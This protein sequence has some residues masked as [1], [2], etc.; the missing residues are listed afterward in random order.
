MDIQII[1]RI[2]MY[3]DD[4]LSFIR[5]LLRAQTICSASSISFFRPFY[6]VLYSLWKIFS[7][8]A[9]RLLTCLS[10]LE[11]GAWGCFLITLGFGQSWQIISFS[12]SPWQKALLIR[13]LVSSLVML[14]LE[15]S[16]TN[17]NRLRLEVHL[18]TSLTWT[19]M[20]VLNARLEFIGLGHFHI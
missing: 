16:L 15:S 2:Y 17:W 8:F 18:H 9:W 13:Y 4:L 10:R 6:F 20:K 7:S 3:K 14:V 1:S 5:I 11:V 19:L 12:S